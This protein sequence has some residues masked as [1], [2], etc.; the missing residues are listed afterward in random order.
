VS[1]GSD[2]TKIMAIVALVVSGLALAAVVVTQVVPPLM[3]GAF[4]GGLGPG[5]RPPDSSAV[6]AFS[7]NSYTGAVV[8]ASDGTVTGDVLAAAVNSA[9]RGELLATLTCDPTPKAATGASV[10]C[11]STRAN[12]FSSYA[13]VQ[14]TDDTGRF[15]VMIF[16]YGAVPDAIPSQGLP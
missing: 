7:G 4:G 6:G 1:R 10:L 5:E 8:P 16:T 3:F 15:Q 9:A 2:S 13:V 14:F 12:Q 11:R